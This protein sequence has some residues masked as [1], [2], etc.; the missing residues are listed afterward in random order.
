MRRRNPSGR[1]LASDTDC[2]A[3]EGGGQAGTHI[4]IV[5]TNEDGWCVPYS[6]ETQDGKKRQKKDATAT[7][8]TGV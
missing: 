1:N 5:I 7:V 3:G 8:D 6:N 4:P 2:K